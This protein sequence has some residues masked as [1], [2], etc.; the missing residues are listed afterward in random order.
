MNVPVV[1]VRV[2]RVAMPYGDMLVQVTVFST[3]GRLQCVRML[4]VFIMRMFMVVLQ[5]LMQMLVGMVFRQVQPYAQS[6]QHRGHPER[7]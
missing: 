5:D 4:M 1:N 2:M 6:H 3:R 7:P